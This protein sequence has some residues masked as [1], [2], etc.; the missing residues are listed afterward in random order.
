MNHATKKRF[1]ALLATAALL[2]STSALAAPKL[3]VEISVTKDSVVTE[4]GQPVTKKVAAKEGFPGDL[5]TYSLAYKNSG[6]ANAVGALIVDPIPKGTA[7]MAGS[8]TKADAEVNF[9]IDGGKTYGAEPITFEALDE[10]G[11]KV[12]KTATPEM[13]TH[14][15]WKLTKPVPAGGSGI[16][17]FKVKVL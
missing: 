2:L 8:A 16:L 4:N 11:N 7:Y 9:S 17:E 10:K 3:T 15:R 14:V 6:D 13:Y 1:G 5:L 12:T